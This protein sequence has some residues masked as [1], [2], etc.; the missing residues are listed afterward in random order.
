MNVLDENI[1]EDQRQLLRSWR[2]RAYQIGREI[3]RQGLKDEQQII[4]LL[5]KLRRPTFFTRDLG[6]FGP[7][8]CHAK[9]CL[10][11]LAIEA[12]EAASFV[13]RV[14]R[15]SSFDTQVKRIGRVLQVGQMGI[16]VL[17]L[18]GEEETVDW[19]S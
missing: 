1:P 17:Q 13:R 16:R 10:V 11:C 7:E 19:E 5:L 2:I 15:H 18:R 4:P 14:L 6:F 12:D 9:Y 3:G 8:F